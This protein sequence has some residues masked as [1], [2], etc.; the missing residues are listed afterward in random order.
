MH[1]GHDPTIVAAAWKAYLATF[2]TD[3][4]R[5]SDLGHWLRSVDL[6][7]RPVDYGD[8]SFETLYAIEAV[9]AE[10]QA[11]LERIKNGALPEPKF[12]HAGSGG[13]A[14]WYVSWPGH[15]ELMPFDV[16]SSDAAMSE[17][18]DA[19][20]GWWESWKKQHQ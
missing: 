11:E 20:P 7:N 5:A 15:S 14:S 9:K 6:R 16:V 2:G 18:I 4:K 10:A 12:V 17:C 19:W 8:Q 13:T 3:A 1:E